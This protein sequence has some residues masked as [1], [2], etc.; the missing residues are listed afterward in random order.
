MLHLAKTPVYIT[1]IGTGYVGLVSGACFASLGHQVVCV[2]IDVEKISRL[3][4]GIIPIYEPNLDELVTTQMKEGRLSFTTDLGN[5]LEKAQA[6]FI[7]VGTPVDLDNGRA[8]LTYIKQADLDV[9]KLAKQP[10]LLVHKSTVPVGTAHMIED[11]LQEKTPNHSLQIASNPEFLREG[12]AI[13]DF[14]KPDRIVVGTDNMQAENLLRRIYQPLTDNGVPIVVCKRRSAEMIKYAANAFLAVKIAYINEMS[15]LCEAN[16]ANID[17]VVEG[18]GLDKR[19]NSRFLAVGPG[20]G[21][22]CFPKDTLELVGLGVESKVD[23]QVIT[24]AVKANDERK[25]SLWER[26]MKA[27]PSGHSPANICFALLGS[28]FKANTDDMRESPALDLIPALLQQGAD[29]RLYDPQAMQNTQEIL[30]KPENLTYCQNM[31]TVMQGADAA[32]ILTEWD[33]FANLTPDYYSQYLSLNLLID[34]RNLYKLDVMQSSS[35]TYISM[36]R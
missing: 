15:D 32:I 26:V 25:Q 1:I 35:L 34:F 18:I 19:I 21:G 6:C 17:E 2:D 8:D 5:A 33:E 13:A 31:D 20:Y 16:H 3:K 22:S 29:I 12:H 9:A 14:M 10:L 28:A 23:L 36:G 30:G 4:R 7:A 24:G 11:F 27:L